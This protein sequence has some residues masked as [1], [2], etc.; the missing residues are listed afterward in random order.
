MPTNALKDRPVPTCHKNR[1]G[2]YFASLLV[3]EQ[4]YSWIDHSPRTDTALLDA[5]SRTITGVVGQVAEAVVHIQVLKPMA[6]DR[7][8]RPNGPTRRGPGQR[9][10]QTPEL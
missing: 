4:K 5:Y 8:G 7:G 1:I 9:Q 6:M 10:G 2:R 3:M